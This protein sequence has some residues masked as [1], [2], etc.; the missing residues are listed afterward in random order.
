MISSSIPSGAIVYGPKNKPLTVLEDRGQ[1]LAVKDGDRQGTVN[2][3]KIE[4][5]QYG[6]FYLGD[7]VTMADSYQVRAGDVGTVEAVSD[8]GIQVLWDNKV[9]NWPGL[10]QPPALHR[11][12]EATELKLIESKY[13]QN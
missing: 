6:G 11:T 4:R 13:L 7:R 12:F 3:S 1:T 8:K 9:A 2:R 5:W 10:K